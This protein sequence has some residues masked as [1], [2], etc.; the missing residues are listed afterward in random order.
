M[1]NF[2]RQV[3]VLAISL[4]ASMQASAYDFEAEGMYYNVISLQDSTVEI[5]SGDNKYSGDVAIPETVIY[6]GGTLTVTKIGLSA[7]Y[8]CSSLESVTIP[9][10]VKTIEPSAFLP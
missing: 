5:T 9:N 3:F 1:R 8:R 2:T 6:K 4:L 10:S 7:F